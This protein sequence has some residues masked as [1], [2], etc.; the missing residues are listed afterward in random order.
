M[1]GYICI[2]ITVKI[3]FEISYGYF[4]EQAQ[5]ALILWDSSVADPDVEWDVQICGLLEIFSKE[6]AENIS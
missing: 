3:S 4:V 6:Y 1:I 5:E 2:K